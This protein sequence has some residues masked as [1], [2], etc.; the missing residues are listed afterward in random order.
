MHNVRT[1]N[2]AKNEHTTHFLPKSLVI[3][4]VSWLIINIITLHG[5]KMISRYSNR[6]V[7]YSNT[8]VRK[9]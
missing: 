8:T 4:T 6:A 7:T 9:S 2:T 5:N 3:F 1:K